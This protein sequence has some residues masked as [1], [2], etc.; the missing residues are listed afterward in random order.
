MLHCTRLRGWLGGFA[1]AVGHLLD[2]RL[3]LAERVANLRGVAGLALGAVMQAAAHLVRAAA[4]FG[5]ARR[6]LAQRADQFSR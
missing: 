6:S 5:D 1:G 3:Q 4:A 2:G